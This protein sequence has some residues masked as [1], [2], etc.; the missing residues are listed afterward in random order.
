MRDG[1][2][3]R[4]ETVGGWTPAFIYICCEYTRL[5]CGRLSRMYLLLMTPSSI[6]HLSMYLATGMCVWGMPHGEF[7]S[8]MSTH[9]RIDPDMSKRAVSPPSGRSMLCYNRFSARRCR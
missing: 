6:F 3:Y 7:G 9:F 5:G 4:L 2:S 1:Q 8:D